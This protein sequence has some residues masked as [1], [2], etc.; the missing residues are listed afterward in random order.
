MDLSPPFQGVY[1]GQL[2]NTHTQTF[3]MHKAYKEQLVG[4]FALRIDMQNDNVFDI[5]VG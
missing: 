4:L 5:Y 2:T 3:T 1:H